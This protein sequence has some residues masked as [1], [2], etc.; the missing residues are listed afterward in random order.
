MGPHICIRALELPNII[1]SI[2]DNNVSVFCHSMNTKVVISLHTITFS[3]PNAI[4][5][6]I[7]IGII[8]DIT[9]TV[10]IF[11][12]ITTNITI[13]IMT[14]LA[15]ASLAASASAAMAS[16]DFGAASNPSPG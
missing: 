4:I 1:V 14:T 2:V 7:N 5:I 9:V 16:G 6:F 10:I 12:I 15:L 13:N 11:V 8:M 3:C